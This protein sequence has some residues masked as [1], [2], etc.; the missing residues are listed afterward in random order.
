MPKLASNNVCKNCKVDPSVKVNLWLANL[1]VNLGKEPSI[2]TG[3]PSHA[4]NRSS[5]G[6]G[7]AKRYTVPESFM[8]KAITGYSMLKSANAIN[9]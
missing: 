7:K 8:T 2:L 3:L 1:W 5:R 6:G 4:Y 9:A